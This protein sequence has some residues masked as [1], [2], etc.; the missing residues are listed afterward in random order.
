LVYDRWTAEGL[1]NVQTHSSQ[2]RTAWT[3]RM[4]RAA[5][6][7]ERSPWAQQVLAFYSCVLELQRE[8]YERTKI[9]DSPALANQA[10]L[11]EA[12][13]LDEAARSFPD[14]VAVVR[15]NGPPKLAQQASRLQ[16]ASGPQI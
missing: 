10:G 15:E 12:L 9:Q 7:A 13:N 3:K 14:L 1:R 16:T 6:L 5:E 4:D 8:I 11:R 2:G